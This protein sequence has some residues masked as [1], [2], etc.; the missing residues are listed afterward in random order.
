MICNSSKRLRMK[1]S[2]VTWPSQCFSLKVDDSF[3]TMQQKKQASR[4]FALWKG[5]HVSRRF[6]FCSYCLE[7]ITILCS[8]DLFQIQ[9]RFFGSLLSQDSELVYNLRGKAAAFE[10]ELLVKK[11][12]QLTLYKRT[13]ATGCR[14]WSVISIRDVRWW[15]CRC[16]RFWNCFYVI[17]LSHF[18]IVQ[19]AVL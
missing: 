11:K 16:L 4:L 5:G 6:K 7:R 10:C 3:F 13:R 12:K 17:F 2:D 8:M 9:H 15:Y 14:L 19:R 1:T 18:S